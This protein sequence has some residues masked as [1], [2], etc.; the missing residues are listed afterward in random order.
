M[1]GSDRMQKRPIKQLVDSLRMLGAKIEY[2]EEE[3]F[4]PLEILANKSTIDGGEI[5][6]DGTISSQ[7][8]SALLLIAPR[9]K[10]GLIISLKGKIVSKPY[11]EMTNYFNEVF[12]S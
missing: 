8:I 6:I 10:N 1:T 7:Y 4:P 2:Q 11:I 12:W 5:E 9:L 3:G